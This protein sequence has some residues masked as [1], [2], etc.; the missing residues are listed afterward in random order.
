MK[1]IIKTI[2]PLLGPHITEDNKVGWKESPSLFTRSPAK[3]VKQLR[4]AFWL[5]ST[6][7]AGD[8]DVMPCCSEREKQ[9]CI[10]LSDPVLDTSVE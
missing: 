1:K 8:S 4:N 9:K 6:C 2:Q 3:K 10:R 7:L 5:G